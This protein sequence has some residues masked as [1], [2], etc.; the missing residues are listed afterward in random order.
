MGALQGDQTFL[1]GSAGERNSSAGAG[2]ALGRWTRVV[3]EQRLQRGETSCDMGTHGRG[4]TFPS[5]FYA[6]VP[7]SAELLV[8]TANGS[9]APLL[10]FWP[11]SR[12]RPGLSLGPAPP[13]PKA[14]PLSAELPSSTTTPGPASVSSVS[15]TKKM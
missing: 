3:L 14:P 4:T 5:P 13:R 12:P 11:V 9:Y 1:R 2:G 7:G 10:P 8:S 6:A 15:K